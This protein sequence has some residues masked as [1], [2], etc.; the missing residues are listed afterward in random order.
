MDASADG[1]WHDGRVHADDRLTYERLTASADR[2]DSLAEVAEL[3]DDEAGALRF[4]R[5]AERHR[6]EA[7]AMLDD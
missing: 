1:R 6:S 4:R 7:M 5:E 2:L 3:M